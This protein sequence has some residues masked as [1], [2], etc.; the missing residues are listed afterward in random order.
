MPRPTGRGSQKCDIQIHVKNKQKGL[1]VDELMLACVTLVIW[2]KKAYLATMTSLQIQT[3]PVAMSK[4]PAVEKIGFILL[5]G[6]L[7]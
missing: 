6:K 7:N 5:A 4:L 3:M 2:F 1:H